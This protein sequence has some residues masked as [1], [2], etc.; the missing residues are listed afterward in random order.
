MPHSR[1]VKGILGATIAVI[2]AA[3]AAMFAQAGGQGRG[4]GGQNLPA[5]IELAVGNA[6]NNPF[7]ML[8][9]T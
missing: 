2:V 1:R 3:S 7:R 6:M 9:V 4:R 5:P 8:S